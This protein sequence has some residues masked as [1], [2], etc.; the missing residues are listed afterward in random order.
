MAKTSSISL[1]APMP[2]KTVASPNAAVSLATDGSSTLSKT[3]SFE[4]TLKSA[5]KPKASKADDAQ[6]PSKAEKPASTKPAKASKQKASRS[7]GA[8]R[9]A[10][11]SADEVD[12]SDAEATQAPDTEVAQTAGESPVDTKG[13]AA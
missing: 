2:P 10:D 5:Q 8:K 13:D 6:T 9:Q 4:Q 12:Q 7:T 3:G 1:F 11:S